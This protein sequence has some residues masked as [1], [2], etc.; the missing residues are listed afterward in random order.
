MTRKPHNL[1]VGEAV[2]FTREKAVGLIYETYTFVDGPGARPGVSVLLSDG[3]NLSGFSA[4]EA[5]YFLEPLGDT[6][7]EYDFQNVGQLAQDYQ[8]GVFDQA[9]TTAR[10]L[11]GFKHIDA[12]DPK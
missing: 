4:T 7:L 9:F 5:D 2:Y 3:K 11:A 8:R 10:L 12:L 6:G 1:T